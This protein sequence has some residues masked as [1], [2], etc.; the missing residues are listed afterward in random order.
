MLSII[1]V[2]TAGGLYIAAALVGP[3][4]TIATII[5]KGARP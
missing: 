4:T 3:I 1:V 5:R 2:S